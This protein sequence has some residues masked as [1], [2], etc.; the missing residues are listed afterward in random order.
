MTE[1]TGT[2]DGQLEAPPCKFYI[3]GGVKMREQNLL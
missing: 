2:D 1:G 3:M